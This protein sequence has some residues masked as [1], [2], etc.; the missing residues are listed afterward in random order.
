MR[1]AFLSLM[2]VGCT[3][4]LGGG[5]PSP[6]DDDETP[7]MRA[8]V[9]DCGT[10]APVSTSHVYESL[11]P[12]CVGCHDENAEAPLFATAGNYEAM[13]VRNAR[14]IAPS[15][16]DESPLLAMLEGKAG[17][18]QMPPPVPYVTLADANTSL[19]SLAELRCWVAALDPNLG[20]AE[21]SSSLNRRIYGEYLQANLFWALGLSSADFSTGGQDYGLEDPDTTYPRSPRSQYRAQQLGMPN[22]LSG[23]PRANELGTTFVQVTVQLSQ[24]WCNKV[25]AGNRVFF[26]YATAADG[27]STPASTARVRE[28][29]A[30]VFERVTGETASAETMEGLM[31]LFRRYDSGTPRAGWAAACSGIVRHPLSLT[32]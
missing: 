26:K 15:N 7:P 16:P 3:G 31:E 20:P 2:A 9:A 22:W 24:A 11:R 25:N 28:N 27:L 21:V 19:P 32:F 18:A 14:F 23:I 29:L 1:V 17:V 10:L 5:L 8:R 6:F 30:Y 4:E 13:V 12:M